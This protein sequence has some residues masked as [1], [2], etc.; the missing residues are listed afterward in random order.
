MIFIVISIDHL[1]LFHQESWMKNCMR[2]VA[3]V[4]AMTSLLAVPA[5]AGDNAG[6]EATMAAI[7]PQIIQIAD[8]IHENPES[9]NKEYKAVAL[10]TKTLADNGF[11]IEMPV[12]GLETA[13]IATYKNSGGGPAISFMAEYDAL[14]GLGHG[15]GHNLI[16]ASCAGAAIALSKNLGDTPAT[17][18][19]FGCPAE[20]TTSGKIAIANAGLFERADVGLQMHP[21]S[22]TANVGAY[23]LALNLVDFTFDGK[24]SHAAA[25]P[26]LGRSALDGVM[27]LFNGIEYL[28]EHIRQDIRIHG[29][30]TNGGQAA[31]IVPEKAAAR[32]Y[33][34]GIQRPY[35]DSVVER[36]YAV[37]KGA[38]MATGTTVTITPIKQY[39][40][41]VNVSS[42]MDLIQKESKAAGYAEMPKPDFSAGAG[43]STDFGTASSRIPCVMFSLPVSTEPVV[44]HSR[45]MVAATFTPMGRESAVKAADIMA[46]AGYELIVNPTLLATIKAEWKVA[47]GGGK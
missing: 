29:I 28:R 3:I 5:F 9:G 19:V 14:D 40:N 46:Q 8:Y 15:C 6:I 41:V 30:V 34:R 17:V 35:L 43:A 10:L 45:D 1:N 2:I 12:A 13:F 24:A 38:A 21:G 22:N 32:F 31:N 20:E 37:A 47:V 33:V 42:F 44:G 25:S 11:V 39:D 36:V 7:K 26:E 27:M 16:A 23:T 18:I 4:I